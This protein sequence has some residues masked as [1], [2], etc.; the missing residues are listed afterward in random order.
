MTQDEFLEIQER[1]WASEH[2]D[3]VYGAVAQVDEKKN[4]TIAGK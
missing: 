4:F 1:F 2:R 3:R